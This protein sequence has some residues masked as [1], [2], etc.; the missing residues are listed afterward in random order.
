M[1]D[2]S[3]DAAIAFGYLKAGGLMT[4]YGKANY[5]IGTSEKF[6]LSVKFSAATAALPLYNW[7]VSATRFESKGDRPTLSINFGVSLRF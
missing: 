3:I 5:N 7:D 4:P 6:R 2:L 1:D